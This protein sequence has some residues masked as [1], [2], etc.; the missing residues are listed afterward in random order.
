MCRNVQP[1]PGQG[2]TAP[3]QWP[4]LIPQ[5][6]DLIGAIKRSK[7]LE[8]ALLRKRRVLCAVHSACVLALLMRASGR[9]AALPET[10]DFKGKSKDSEEGIV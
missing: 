4:L 10:V 3:T 7:Q 1:R 6:A 2:P 5:S 8:Q 9:A